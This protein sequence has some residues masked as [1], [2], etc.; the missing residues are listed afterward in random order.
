MIGAWGRFF[1]T[2][3]AT[4]AGLSGLI[5]VALSINLAKIMETEALIKRAAEALLMM[6]LPIPFGL[7]LLAPYGHVA[8]GVVTLTLAVGFSILLNILLVR[9]A[10]EIERGEGRQ[11]YVT[12]VVLVEVV[13]MCE[14]IG[15]ILLLSGNSSTF[16]W[17][18]FGA[19][20]GVAIG[21]LDSWVLLVEILR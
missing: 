5:F 18:G 20:G 19:L 16:G 8:T 15:A 17:I 12:R 3:V 9:T 14:L 4:S 13:M 7:T 2:E 11:Q 10:P 6:V 1:T 21:M